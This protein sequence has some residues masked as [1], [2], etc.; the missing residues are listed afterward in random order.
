MPRAMPPLAAQ[1]AQQV[2][3]ALLIAEIGERIRISSPRGSVAWRELHPAR[4]EV[5][6]EMAYLRIFMLWESYLE[7]SFLR[8][9]C[10][11]STTVG[12]ASLINPPQKT[13]A[14]RERQCWVDAHLFHGHS[15]RVSRGYVV[16]L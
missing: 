2:D 15:Q 9:L 7:E 5:L 16:A 1:F 14:P 3:K 13:L 6:Y 11:Y 12:L 8:Y 4:L 10:G